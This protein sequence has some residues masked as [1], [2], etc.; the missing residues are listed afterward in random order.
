MR[1]LSN[2]GRPHECGERGGWNRHGLLR[3]SKGERQR[4]SDL[5][6]EHGDYHVP[7]AQRPARRGPNAR[8]SFAIAGA[9]ARITRC[10]AVRM[11]RRSPARW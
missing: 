3:S 5:E 10:S 8:S 1:P 7:A 11:T 2:V 9:D 6:I 4:G